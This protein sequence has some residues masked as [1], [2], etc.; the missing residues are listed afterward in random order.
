MGYDKVISRFE[1]RVCRNNVVSFL[2]THRQTHTRF[3]HS[4]LLF[5]V[6][7][8]LFLVF[9]PRNAICEPVQIGTSSVSSATANSSSRKSFYDTLN[10]MHWA[11]WYD[12]TQIV[13][14]KSSDAQNWA[15]VGNFSY[16]TSDFSVSYKEVS[17][18]SY[19]VLVSLANNYDIVL[20]RGVLS[21]SGVLFDGEVVALN[22]TTSADAYSKVSVSFDADARVWIGAMH[23]NASNS[24]ER[25]QVKAVRS[26][27]DVSNEI[28]SW[29][30]VFN[31]SRRVD[32]I[33]SVVVVP[34]SGDSMYLIQNGDSGNVVGYVFDGS[35]WSGANAG[36]IIVGFR[37][38]MGLLVSKF[39]RR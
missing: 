1:K 27:L 5:V 30:S 29:G 4:F 26:V 15:S 39:M 19:V 37:L 28:N 24:F 38:E 12:G 6:L 16:N 23:D 34:Q 13:Y 22:G 35:A 3:I 9:L 20:R 10:H 32:N 7:S 21:S 8:F 36:G 14:S 2:Y 33:K 18:T 17:G 25:Y 31:V 11:F